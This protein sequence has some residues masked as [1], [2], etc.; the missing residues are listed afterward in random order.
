MIDQLTIIG[1]GLIGG[2]FAKAL[3]KAAIVKHVV[4][5]G[6]QQQNLQIALELGI[7]DQYSDN[8]IDAVKNA[9]V[10]FIATPVST[11]IDIFS[12]LKDHIKPSAI[13]TDAG[14]TKVNVINMSKQVFGQV[15]QNYVPGHPIAGTENSGATAAF[16]ELFVNHKVILT[17]L[18]KQNETQNTDTHALQLVSDL[19]L[20]TGAELVCMDAEHHDLVLGATSHLPHIIAFSLVN[21]LATLNDRKEIFEYAAGGFKDF[22]RI[23]SSSPKMWQD[24]CIANKDILLSHLNHFQDDL[25]QVIYALEND[26]TNYLNQVFSRA[27][28]TRDALVKIKE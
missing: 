24:I 3:K 14:S 6:R 12:Q 2:S 1:V 9:D 17:P 7:I 28:D 22:T 25:S 5:Y 10:I 21:T 8:I 15:P 26:D 19:W 23:A 16:A 18:L 11:F 13:I 20:A 27:K 4:G